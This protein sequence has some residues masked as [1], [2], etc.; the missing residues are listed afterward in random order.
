MTYSKTIQHGNTDDRPRSAV[1]WQVMA[2]G[3]VLRRGAALSP[4][5][6]L[7][8]GR[9]RRSASASQ[10][11]SSARQSLHGETPRFAGCFEDQGQLMWMPEMLRAMTRRW[12][13]EVPSKIV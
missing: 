9:G 3:R 4:T 13:S 1:K 10:G 5:C 2:T 11:A 6:V 12:I 8:V 7:V